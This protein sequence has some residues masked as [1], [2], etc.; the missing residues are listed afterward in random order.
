MTA[1]TLFSKAKAQANAVRPVVQQVDRLDAWISRASRERFLVETPVTPELA[2]RLLERNQENR[3]T[4]PLAVQQ[5]A[6][7]MLRGEWALNGQNII[8]SDTGELNDGQHRL[9]AVVAAGIPVEL[10]I[11]FGVS[12]E[13]RAT[14]DTGRKRTLGDHLA[15]AGYQNTM[16]LA[17][18]V[19]LAWC[20][21]AELWSLSDSPSVEQTFRYIETYPEVGAFISRGSGIGA[22]FKTSGSQF[23]F[24]AFVCARVNRPVASELLDRVHDGLGLTAAN[25]PTA[26]V[27]ERLMMHLTGRRKFCRNEPSAVFIKAFNA[28]LNGRRMRAVAWS[29]FGPAAEAFPV[30]GA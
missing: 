14:L 7:A 17:A 25:L 23:A 1:A 22:E 5:F 11:Q 19:R 13:S 8:V 29:N 12:R 4:S 9:Q 24:A 20:Y 18:T 15:M 3:T 2:A 26:R 28:A 27:R 6:A 30:A 21:D 16:A 10:G